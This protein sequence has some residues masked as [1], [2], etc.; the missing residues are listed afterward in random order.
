MDSKSWIDLNAGF[1]TKYLYIIKKVYGPF[2]VKFLIYKLLIIVAIRLLWILNRIA[3]SQVLTIALMAESEEELKSL[4]MKVK[5]ES[6]KVGLK[7]NI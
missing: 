6:E 2:C 4:L 3:Q 1:A 5:K 7:F